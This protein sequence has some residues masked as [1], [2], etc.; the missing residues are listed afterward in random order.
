MNFLFNKF[1]FFPFKSLKTNH[2][3]EKCGVEKTKK[4]NA[5][6]TFFV[7]MSCH[8]TVAKKKKISPAQNP[9]SSL[10]TPLFYVSFLV[11]F[12]VGL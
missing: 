6:S 11:G 7:L 12:F 3:E 1:V 8:T 10:S 5:F 4:S 9:L 2:D